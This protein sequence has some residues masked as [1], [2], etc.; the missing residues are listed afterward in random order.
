MDL[1]EALYYAVM[2][3]VKVYKTIT[4]CLIYFFLPQFKSQLETKA[5]N[6]DVVIN[7]PKPWDP[8]IHDERVYCR[9]IQDKMLGL[10]EAYME[11]WW[12]CDRLDEACA[13]IA[14]GGMFGESM[15]LPGNFLA[16]LQYELFNLQTVERSWKVAEK[17]YNIGD[18][19]LNRFYFKATFEP[20]IDS[21]N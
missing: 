9:V 17:H 19:F 1:M 18:Y 10:G 20:F 5:R 2:L 8:Q 21:A 4:H 12:D 3:L 16:W 13:R 15:L 11:G 6:L 14:R 7:G